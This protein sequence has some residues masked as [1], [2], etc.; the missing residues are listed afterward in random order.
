MTGRNLNTGMA[1][2][3]T[4]A[5]WRREDPHGERGR[6]VSDSAQRRGAAPITDFAYGC[7]FHFDA[8]PKC[9]GPCIAASDPRES[10]ACRG[11][12]GIGLSQ[13]DWHERRA[14]WEALVAASKRQT[15]PSIWA[16]LIARF[17]L[18]NDLPPPGGYPPMPD[19]WPPPPAPPPPPPW[20]DPR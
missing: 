8:L 16:W 18:V 9:A 5:Y 15:S 20:M 17:R 12:D 10:F 6:C 11:C 14:A 4:C 3:R 1:T 7:T 19:A 13:P 2:C